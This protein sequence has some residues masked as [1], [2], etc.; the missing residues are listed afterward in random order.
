MAW[1][2]NR[3]EKVEHSGRTDFSSIES[4]KSMGSDFTTPA[5][6]IEGVSEAANSALMYDSGSLVADWSGADT[7]KATMI[8]EGSNDDSNW[9]EINGSGFQFKD[10]SGVQAWEFTQFTFKHIRA[11]F[12]AN[13]NTAGTLNLNFYGRRK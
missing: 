8:L 4:S 7:N 11:V 6:N 9:A 1:S 2:P 12:T 3:T 10:A 5:I 13:S